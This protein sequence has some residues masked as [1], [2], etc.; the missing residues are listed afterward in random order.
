METTISGGWDGDGRTS[1]SL[2]DNVLS[3][4]VLSLVATTTDDVVVVFVG[5]NIGAVVVVVR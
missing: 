4:V 3:G 1:A 5:N 2:V